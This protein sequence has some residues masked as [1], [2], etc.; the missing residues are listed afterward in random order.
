MMLNRR[1][2]IGTVALAAAGATFA[3]P[4]ATDC[5]Y[6]IAVAKPEYHVFSRVFQFIRDYDRAAA[7]MRQCGVCLIIVGIAMA[8]FMYLRLFPK[9]RKPLCERCLMRGTLLSC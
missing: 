7:V 3:A 4:D 8:S 2:F 5:V 6:P 9:A 1:D